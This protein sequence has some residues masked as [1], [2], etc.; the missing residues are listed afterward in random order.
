MI[1]ARAMDLFVAEKLLLKDDSGK[2]VLSE[3]A[4]DVKIDLLLKDLEEDDKTYGL[5]AIRFIL[6]ALKEDCETLGHALHMTSVDLLDDTQVETIDDLAIL[7]KVRAK[8]Q[9]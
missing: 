5:H 2:V 3:S 8:K 4:P 7:V 9:S 6:L 1:A